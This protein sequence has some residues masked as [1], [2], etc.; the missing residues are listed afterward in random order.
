MGMGHDR[1]DEGLGAWA[2][3]ARISENNHRHFYRRW[4]DLMTGRSWGE[5]ELRNAQ[6]AND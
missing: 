4:A 1:Y 2:S 5:L 3:E 6:A